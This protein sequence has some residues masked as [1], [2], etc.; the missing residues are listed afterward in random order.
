[1]LF[2][3]Q[4]N[5]ANGTIS[6]NSI[7]FLKNST[8]QWHCGGDYMVQTV[9]GSYGEPTWLGLA[10]ASYHIVRINSSL[11]IIVSAPVMTLS[12]LAVPRH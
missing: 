5:M 3:D 2:L 4:N 8:V 10:C 1:M 11:A 7:V 6:V 12:L 9:Y